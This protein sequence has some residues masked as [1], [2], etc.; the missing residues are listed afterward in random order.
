MR[1][2]LVLLVSLL[3]IASMASAPKMK[4]YDKINDDVLREFSSKDKVKVIVKLKEGKDFSAI[5]KRKKFASS[6]AFAAEL[7]AAEL[8]GLE[9]SGEVEKVYIDGK[10][11][12]FLQDSVPLIGGI[13]SEPL[14]INGTRIT[15]EGQSVCVIDTGINYTHPDF[16]SCSSSQ[17]LAGNCSKVPSGYDFVNS[18]ADPADDNSHGTHVS[19]I[20]AANGT[21]RGVAPKAKII[22]IKALD[23]N[24]DG[25]FSDVISGIDWCAA[26][27]IK[28]NITAISMSLGTDI[29]FSSD[30]D[31]F[32]SPTTASVNAAIAKN[33]TV[34]AASGN[35]GSTTGISLPACISGVISVASSTKSDSVSPFS[36]RNSITDV[37]A[38]GSSI[39]STVPGGY[40]TFSGTSM[41]TPHVAGAIALLQQFK[42]DESNVSLTPSQAENALKQTGKGIF[43]SST[44]LTLKRTD[45]FNA[46]LFVDSKPPA[47]TF[48]FPPNNTVQSATSITVNSSSTETLLS[49]F[50][51]SGSNY[52][53]TVSGNVA[54]LTLNLTEG[55]HALR[56]LGNDSSGKFGSTE[57][58]SITID[59]TPPSLDIA[60]PVNN[61]VYFSSS[62]NLSYVARDPFGLSCL[63]FNGTFNVLSGCENI[64]FKAPRGNQNITVLVNDTAGNANSTTVFFTVNPPPEISVQSPINA[65]Y[66]YLP[67][68]NFTLFDDDINTTWYSIDG[69][70]N[71][72]ITGNTTLTVQDGHHSIILSSNDS[73]GHISSVYQEFTID[74]TKPAL[75]FGNGTPVN[76]TINSTNTVAFFVD[77]SEP[78]SN[79]TL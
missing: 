38:P 46:L 9:N 54:S 14:G 33:I 36:N 15:G 18:D 57:T 78:L 10:V 7:S 21:K 31:S 44:G 75:S 26:N 22:S 50:L 3:L 28:F 2:A 4:K 17:F 37:I 53:M 6:N 59:Y 27:A 69:L 65:S 1:A 11:K 20:I 43:D 71:F 35:S 49:A 55:Y 70:V 16:G 63:F 29:L 60:S 66:N 40:A 74:A 73:L 67:Y 23:N 34:V 58:R 32:D 47:I 25:S 12:A 48:I 13:S 42:R 61:S 77:S 76:K 8:E 64:T 5:S 72:T 39:S 79:A 30:C 56:V 62:I 68:L 19:G 45:V 51:E 41:A 52:T 24:G